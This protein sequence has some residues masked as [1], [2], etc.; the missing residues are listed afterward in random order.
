MTRIAQ[1]LL[2]LQSPFCVLSAQVS[3]TR[4]V[5][6]FVADSVSGEAL[7]EARVEFPA[8]GLSRTTDPFGVAYFPTVKTGVVTIIVS[9]I[10]YVPLQRSVTLELSSAN[11]I[12]LSVAMKG[13]LV[14][15]PLD[16]VKVIAQRTYFDLFSDFER[17]RRSGIGKYF[18]LAQLDSA[19][20]ESLADLITRRVTGKRAQWSDSR[21]GVRLVSLRGPVSVLRQSQCFV[22]VY[23]NNNK[24]DAEE[25]AHIQAGDVA[26]VEY[27]S[28]A[29]PVQYS[30]D[31]PCGVLLVWMKR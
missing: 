4:P 30:S 29:P 16:T 26:G 1:A 25:L 10:G 22:E 9:K 19:P 27:Y 2:L 15:Q 5:S 8:F 12:E 31:A 18:T 21:L 14:T 17:R 20:H 7:M 28:I 13:I 3:A 24:A 11:A 6:V 23:R